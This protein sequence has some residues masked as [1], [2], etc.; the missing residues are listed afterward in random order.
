MQRLLR[1]HAVSLCTWLVQ[2]C[3]RTSCRPCSGKAPF[4]Q[5]WLPSLRLDRCQKQ[6]ALVQTHACTATAPSFRRTGA[7]KNQKK[8][9]RSCSHERRQLIDQLTDV[10]RL[11]SQ[12]L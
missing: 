1:R 8:A 3:T 9:L 7:E 12:E 10:F 2:Q 4:L 11:A 5:S 6:Q